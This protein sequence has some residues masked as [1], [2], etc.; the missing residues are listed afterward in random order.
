[1]PV[2]PSPMSAITSSIALPPIATSARTVGMQD[3]DNR[4][5]VRVDDKDYSV[6][7]LAIGWGDAAGQSIELPTADHE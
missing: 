7:A 2:R 5:T 1:M 4:V 3:G 6:H